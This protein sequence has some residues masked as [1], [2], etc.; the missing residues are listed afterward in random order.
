MERRMDY[1]SFLTGGKMT[2]PFEAFLVFS[3]NLNPESLGDEAFLRR[4][5]YK[6]LLRGP[7]RNEFTRIFE[8][9]CTDKKLAF[10]RELLDGF[11]DKYYRDRGKVFRR[12]HP[13]DVLTHAL[14][15]RLRKAAS[16]LT[17]NDGSG[18]RAVSCRKKS[19]PRGSNLRSCA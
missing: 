11:V 9:V 4:I 2:V 18:L 14:T 6:M 8:T 12:C 3:T 5:Q 13:R 10:S 15:D 16:Q 19:P 17:E 1:L 7:G